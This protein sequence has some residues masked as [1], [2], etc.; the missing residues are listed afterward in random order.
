M[1]M[2]V[3]RAIGWVIYVYYLNFVEEQIWRY[4]FKRGSLEV[5]EEE[6]SVCH[7]GQHVEMHKS[8]VGNYINKSLPPP[9]KKN[10]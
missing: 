5:V 9:K 2:F 1:G 3:L 10:T 7:P 6:K 8:D 4:N